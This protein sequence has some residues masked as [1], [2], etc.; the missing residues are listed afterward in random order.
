MKFFN[1]SPI[2]RVPESRSSD[3][4]PNHMNVPGPPIV[5]FNYWFV[6]F[7]FLCHL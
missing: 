4:T 1:R 6:V 7:F 2:K 3:R 5:Y